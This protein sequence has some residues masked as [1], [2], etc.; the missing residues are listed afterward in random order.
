MHKELTIHLRNDLTVISIFT[1][2]SGLDWSTRLVELAYE[3]DI[4][5]EEEKALWHDI[6]NR[7][8]KLLP[9]TLKGTQY[10]ESYKRLLSE[11]VILTGFNLSIT[12]EA[13]AI[14]KQS[15]VEIDLLTFRLEEPIPLFHGR[16]T[17]NHLRRRRTFL[18]PR[19]SLAALSFQ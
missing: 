16:I 9:A 8:T 10:R 11:R 4:F 5:T 18:P 3:H 15:M 17:R 6:V 2:K 12:D 13:I 19:A 7:K 14:E 1:K